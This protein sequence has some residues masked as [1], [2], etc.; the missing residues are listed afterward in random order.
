MVKDNPWRPF[1]SKTCKILDLWNWLNEKYS[2][3]V[4][5]I[6]ET[7]INEEVNNDKDYSLWC[8]RKNGQ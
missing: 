7:K 5:E 4:E 3:K 1:C 6:E 8:S 2:I